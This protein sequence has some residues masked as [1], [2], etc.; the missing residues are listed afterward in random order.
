MIL[1]VAAVALTAK[2]LIAIISGSIVGGVVVGG[3]VTYGA[4]R[5]TRKSRQEIAREYQMLD[6]ASAQRKQQRHHSLN[7]VA[8]RVSQE[9]GALMDSLSREQQRTANAVNGL[10]VQI[11]E[12][13]YNEVQLQLILRESQQDKALIQNLRVE[14]RAK[15]DALVNVT[16]EHEALKVRFVEAVAQLEETLMAFDLLKRTLAELSGER[17]YTGLVINKLQRMKSTNERLKQS[18]EEQTQK[19]EHAKHRITGLT[20][21]LRATKDTLLS[22]QKRIADLQ[23]EAED[24]VAQKSQKSTPKQRFF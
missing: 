10:E 24:E 4:V 19:Y 16:D 23:A 14:L 2:A 5:I 1:E 13:K 20:Q 15:T 12:A 18:L 6:E 22:Q 17:D 21:Q 11:D 3:A 7:A 9:S 8:T